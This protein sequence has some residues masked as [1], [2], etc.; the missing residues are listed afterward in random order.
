M[1]EKYSRHFSKE[2]LTKGIANQ[3][4]ENWKCNRVHPEVTQRCDCKEQLPPL[5]QGQQKEEFRKVLKPRSLKEGPHRAGIQ[6]SEEG[7]L[8]G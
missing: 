2:N 8:P 7:V 3:V 5:G 4:S 6:I 1:K